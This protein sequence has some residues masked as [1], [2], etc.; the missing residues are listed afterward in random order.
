M[1]NVGTVFSDVCVCCSYSLVMWF[2]IL[3]II[4]CYCGFMVSLVVLSWG[5]CGRLNHFIM[6]AAPPGM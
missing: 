1:T 4:G 3:D 6:E 5:V 2:C